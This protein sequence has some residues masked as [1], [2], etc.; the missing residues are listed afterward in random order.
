MVTKPTAKLLPTMASVPGIDSPVDNIIK[1]AWPQNVLL[2]HLDGCKV[3]M[4]PRPFKI[5]S[6][7][8]NGVISSIGFPE[9]N[10]PARAT[11]KRN[12]LISFSLDRTATNAL[13]PTPSQLGTE[14]PRSQITALSNSISSKSNLSQIS[15]STSAS[16]KPNSETNERS[17]AHLTNRMSEKAL[18]KEPKSE[19]DGEKSL[20]K[21][22][23][24]K[25]TTD[26]LKPLEQM[27]LPEEL[28][29]QNS[30]VDNLKGPSPCLITKGFRIVN[31]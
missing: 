5:A 1:P 4:P 23:S 3:P 29:D 15:Q 13:K 17:S 26:N 2:L 28:K 9:Q 16:M 18:E 11:K 19:T 31:N 24:F 8:G 30:S 22:F 20:F 27:V 10:K 12:L 14:D 6:T 25:T 21:P 7:T